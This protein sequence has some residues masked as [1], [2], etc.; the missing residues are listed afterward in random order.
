MWF[1]RA[2]MAFVQRLILRLA[3]FSDCHAVIADDTPAI[4]PAIALKSTV[5]ST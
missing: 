4:T 1:L 2:M 5:E 3:L